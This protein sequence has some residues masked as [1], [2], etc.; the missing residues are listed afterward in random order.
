MFDKPECRE[1]D[2]KILDFLARLLEKSPKN[3]YTAKQALESEFF[4]N[5]KVVE[6]LYE[7]H[8][9]RRK[10][11]YDK[12]LKIANIQYWVSIFNSVIFYHLIL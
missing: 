8:E 5:P 9:R 11:R 3:R 2:S 4:T 1:L 7:F 12:I 6:G 10:E